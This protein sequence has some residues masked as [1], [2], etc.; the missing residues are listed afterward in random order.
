MPKQ[1]AA[2]APTGDG[3]LVQDAPTTDPST[4]NLPALADA[5]KTEAELE[6]HI[7]EVLNLPTA[8]APGDKT[9]AT[10]PDKPADPAATA[11][12]TTTGGESEPQPDKPAEPVPP[13]AAPAQPVAKVADAPAAGTAADDL[14]LT[15]KDAEGTEFTIKPGDDIDEVL[16]DFKPTGTGQ[17]MKVLG[18]VQ[19]LNAKADAKAVADTAAKADEAKAADERATLAA[20]D[21]EIQD[22]Q[23]SGRIAKPTLK[24]TDAGFAND[25]A[26]KRV[27]EVFK[28][29]AATNQARAAAAQTAGRSPLFIRSFEDALDKLEIQERKAAEAKTKTDDLEVARRKSAAIGGGAGNA[30]GTA[31]VYRPGS[32]HSIWDIPDV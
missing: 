19:E 27:D 17:V 30:G 16:K 7:T 24:P 9:D 25:P 28:F 11:T 18:Q 22:L 5:S 20:W 6:A 3:A 10:T 13:A 1:A 15:V 8:S 26:A 21:S 4:N 14:V 23:A 29:M 31:N 2:P 32:A 12:A